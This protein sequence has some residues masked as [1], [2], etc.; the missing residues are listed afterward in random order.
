MAY[1]P[2]SE[3]HLISSKRK[4]VVMAISYKKL[5]HMLIDKGMTKQDL[6]RLSG[7]STASLAKLGK[8]EN[9]TTDV[10]LKICR[11]ME[12][13]IGDIMEVIPEPEA[14]VEKTEVTSL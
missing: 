2:V 14:E 12:C 4:D 5:W 3:M 11:A 9:I 10:L 13:D 6:R 1:F 7:I 8:G